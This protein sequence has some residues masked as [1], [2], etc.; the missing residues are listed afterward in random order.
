MKSILVLI[1]LLQAAILFGQKKV[2]ENTCPCFKGIGSENGDLPVFIY[3]F[4]NNA[5]INFCGFWD[6]KQQEVADSSALSFILSEFNVF[7]CKTGFSYAA[8]SAAETCRIIP[9]KDT[10]QIEYVEYL[11]AGT[12]WTWEY[13]EIGSQYITMQR[14]SLQISALQSSYSM[15]K[16]NDKEVDEFLRSVVSQKGIG[17]NWE[18]ELGKLQFLA[19]NGNEKAQTLL[20]DYE[21][22]KEAETSGAIAEMWLNAIAQVKWVRGIRE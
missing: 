20:F 10:V 13:V 16:V 6:E 1:C 8:F 9:M 21:K 5:K 4:S 11:P 17:T 7:D 3:E 14:D 15:K 18:M 2:L 19:M 12:N 22:I